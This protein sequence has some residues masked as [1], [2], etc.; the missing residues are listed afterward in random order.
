MADSLL[1]DQVGLKNDLTLGFERSSDLRKQRSLQVIE[2]HDQIVGGGGKFNL[3]QV[4]LL[5]GYFE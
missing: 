3:L 2:I 1:I 4:S 5:P